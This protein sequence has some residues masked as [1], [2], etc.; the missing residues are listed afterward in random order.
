[1]SDCVFA[2]LELIYEQPGVGAVGLPHGHRFV[3]DCR[4]LCPVS[5]VITND[6]LICTESLLRCYE[7]IIIISRVLQSL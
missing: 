2:E 1:M 5:T 7:Q 3:G 4:N 6:L